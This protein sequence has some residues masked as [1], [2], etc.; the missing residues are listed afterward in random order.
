MSGCCVLRELIISHSELMD[1]ISTLQVEIDDI[2][3]QLIRLL[4]DR[5]LRSRRIGVIKRRNNQ[6]SVDPARAQ[7]QRQRFVE[8]SIEANLDARMADRLISVLIEQVIAE[9]AAP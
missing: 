2:D 9:R 5:F 3:T 1:D 4:K 8:Q 6:P 7:R